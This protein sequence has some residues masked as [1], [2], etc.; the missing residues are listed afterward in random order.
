MEIRIG[1]RV[2]QV[3]DKC[4]T[5]SPRKR[6]LRRYLNRHGVESFLTS[7]SLAEYAGC[8]MDE[9]AAAGAEVVQPGDKDRAGQVPV[10]PSETEAPL[11]PSS[12]DLS[13]LL[14][15]NTKEGP[16]QQVGEVESNGLED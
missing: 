2:F 10:D 15:E 11:S 6:N 8:V 4:P 16:D 3:P 13:L 9:L 14:A 7:Q 5:D 1:D 12:E